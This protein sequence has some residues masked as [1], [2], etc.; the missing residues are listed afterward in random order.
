MA[1]FIVLFNSFINMMFAIAVGTFEI[2][3]ALHMEIFIP[4]LIIQKVG[5]MRKNYDDVFSFYS[6]ENNPWEKSGKEVAKNMLC[7]HN[8][9]N[10]EIRYS[11]DDS[12]NV[13]NAPKHKGQIIL[14]K[15][16]Y[17]G[18]SITS[19]AI[20]AHEAGHAIQEKGKNLI[21]RKA[22]SM[23]GKSIVWA[24]LVRPTAIP[25]F[26]VATVF[27][28]RFLALFAMIS[29][30]CVLFS[31]IFVSFIEIDAS[32]SGMKYIKSITANAAA[33]VTNADYEEAVGKVQKVLTAAF[34]TYFP[35]MAFSFLAFAW[36]LIN[37]YM[38]F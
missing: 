22:F 12:N 24:A 8:L 4:I 17:Y 14:G 9:N 1:N 27:E 30:G 23:R 35:N 33:G 11:I 31:Q 37:F 32:N 34:M 13:Y 18:S 26:I 38:Y 16:I 20:A 10:I 5:M 25:M 28:W 21:L 19:A 15:N 3:H 29:L 2:A 7:N 36:A 6:A